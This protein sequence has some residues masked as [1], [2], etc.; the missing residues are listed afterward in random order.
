M[1]MRSGFRIRAWRLPSRFERARR[2]GGGH[3]GGFHHRDTEDT[4]LGRRWGYILL[5]VHGSPFDVH[6]SPFDVHR[7]TFTVHRSTFTVRRS[8]FDVHRSP[9]TVHRSA[10][11]VQRSPFGVHRSPFTV[12]RSPFGVHRSKVCPEGTTGLSPGF[13]P[14]EQVNNTAPP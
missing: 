10:F 4:E 2:C 8:P 5:S 14:W 9:F 13:Q 7:S 3:G 1:W 6:R 11:G 12:H